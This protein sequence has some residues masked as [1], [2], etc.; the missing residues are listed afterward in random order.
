MMRR[1]LWHAP[2][3]WTNSSASRINEGM[4]TPRFNAADVELVELHRAHDG[5]FQIDVYNLKHRQFDGGWSPVIQREIFE[6][7]HAVAVL[8]YDPTTDQ[9]ILIEQ[10]RV[11]AYAALNSP[12]YDD[13]SSPWLIECVA[14]IIDPGEVPEKVARREMIEESGLEALDLVF[15]CHYF[16]TPGG[17]TESI[18]LYI[19]RVD[20]SAVGGVHGVA[21]E[22]E[23]IRPF[24]IDFK[25]AY[26][27]IGAGRVANSMT[28]I[29][30][31]WLMLNK[32]DILTRWSA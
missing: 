2:I 15:A 29:A 14:G 10:F 12:W 8:P 18:H 24:A 27:G 20:A 19:A 17:S 1:F 28:I 23:D 31:Q 13:A 4:K 5:Y 25:R 9:V 32:E 11:G 6:R 7:G 21:G 30:L 3:G 22:G 16:A 26:D